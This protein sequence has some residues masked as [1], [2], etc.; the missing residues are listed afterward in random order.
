MA[1]KT[2]ILDTLRENLAD[3]FF[4]EA[5][6]PHLIKRFEALG[7]DIS[8]YDITIA[9]DKKS[10]VITT[11][12]RGD[13]I[14]DEHFY[15]SAGSLYLGLD[16]G[17]V[18]CTHITQQYNHKNELRYGWM[19][20]IGEQVFTDAVSYVYGLDGKKTYNS[21]YSDDA[22][23]VSERNRFDSTADL[24]ASTRPSFEK[25]KMTELPRNQFAPFTNYWERY[26]GTSVYREHG[27]SPIHGEYSEIGVTFDGHIEDQTFVRE[28]Y[29]RLYY[30]KSLPTTETELAK[31]MDRLR[32]ECYNEE[33]HEFNETRFRDGLRDFEAS[34]TREY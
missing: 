4:S 34:L 11:K 7:E 16:D 8:I 3:E 24:L 15:G 17:Q 31:E 13:D 18:Y 21:W 14:N 30:H 22:V 29:G 20:H 2:N 1:D 27:R 25:G 32:S 19:T 28:S 9:D 26:A 5:I 33:T 10:L 12:D 23:L 6:Y